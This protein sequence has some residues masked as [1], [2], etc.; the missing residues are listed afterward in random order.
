MNGAMNGWKKNPANLA[1]KYEND[2]AGE[3]VPKSKRTKNI[4][5]MADGGRRHPAAA[6]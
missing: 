5:A 6:R 2:E 3:L 1:P 4:N